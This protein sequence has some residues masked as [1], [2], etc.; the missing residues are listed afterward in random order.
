MSP[1]IDKQEFMRNIE[2]LKRRILG[3]ELLTACYFGNERQALKLIKEGALLDYSSPSDDWFAIHYCARWGMLKTLDL[4]VKMGI[5][6]NI[7]TTGDRETALHKACRTNRE[8]I[9]K[10]LLENGANPN[11][12]NSE[13]QRASDLC[14]KGPLAF[15][16]DNYQEFI[17]TSREI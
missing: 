17:R 14:Y 13:K 5:D 10:F 8:K 6:I 1:H 4:M 3:K 16:V 2:D 7:K 12:L 15:L 11:L 9:C